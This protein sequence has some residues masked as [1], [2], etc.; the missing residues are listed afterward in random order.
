MKKQQFRQLFDLFLEEAA[1][2]AE[3]VLGCKMPRVF[4]VL[5]NGSGY[6]N[7]LTT[8]ATACDQLYLGEDKF[9][10]VIDIGVVAVSKEKITIFVRASSHS[11]TGFENTWNTPMGSG[12]FKLLG[13]ALHIKLLG[14]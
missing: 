14:N 7:Y 10:R 8:V 3:I 4:E 2:D 11:P 9:Y 6:S 5:L 12:P 1:Q 13:T